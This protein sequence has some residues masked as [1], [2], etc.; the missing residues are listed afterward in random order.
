MSEYKEIY[1]KLAPYELASLYAREAGRAAEIIGFAD[2]FNNLVR[3]SENNPDNE[4]IA[5]TVE[6]LIDGANATF[7]NYNRE[8]DK[9]IFKE[10]MMIYY[11]SVKTDFRP[12]FFNLVDSKYRSDINRFSDYVYEKTIFC[13]KAK[14]IQFLK[15]YKASSVNKIKNDPAYIISRSIAEIIAEKISFITRELNSR[16]SV[17]NK[18]YMKA[19]MEFQDGTLFYPD[20]NSTLRVTYGEVKG[21]K[22]IDAVYNMCLKSKS[23]GQNS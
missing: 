20:A 10:L 21:F 3:M 11:D 2:R 5:T 8:I 15:S 22:P 23:L 18:D 9:K 6:R 19:Q 1:T 14:Y 4:R 12:S 17:L 16:L 13:D 7:K